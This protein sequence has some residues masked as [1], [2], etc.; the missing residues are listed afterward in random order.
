MKKAIIA[1]LAMAVIGE[2]AVEGIMISAEPP[3]QNIN[4]G[5]I[6]DKSFKEKEDQQKD[7]VDAKK[8]PEEAIKAEA[9]KAIE[10][11]KPLEKQW[12]ATIPLSPDGLQHWPNGKKMFTPGGQ[13]VGGA[14]LYVQ[15]N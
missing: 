2:Q 3:A 14:N 12:G 11:L 10:D 1:L 8:A 4:K 6:E 15:K 5:D 9:A 13:E 7:I